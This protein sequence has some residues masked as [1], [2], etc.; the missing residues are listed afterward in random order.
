MR[1]VGLVLAI[2]PLWLGA[3]PPVEVQPQADPQ[4]A[5]PEDKCSIEGQVVNAQTGDPLKKA[6]VRLYSNDGRQ[7]NNYSAVTDGGGHF[8]IQAID[9]GNYT[10]FAERNGFTEAQYGAR[11]AGH[12]ST[13]LPLS[14]GQRIRDLNF[15]LVPF[16]VITGRVLDEDGEPV[17]H[18]NV[19][20]TRYG[21]RR[22]QLSQAGAGQTDDLGEYRIFGL[23]AGKYYLS[24][25]YNQRNL[26]ATQ[27]RTPEHGPDEGYARTFYPGTSDPTGAVAINVVPGAQLR[28]VDITLLKTRTW[29]IRGKVINGLGESLPRPV[30]IML[31]PREKA[32]MG[33][34]PSATTQI[35]DADGTFALRGVTSGAYILLAQC[36]DEGKAYVARQPVDVGNDNVENISLLLGSGMDLKGVVRVDGPGGTALGN[37]QVSLAPQEMLRMGMQGAKVAD[38]GSF[39][40]SNV[41]PATYTIDV[42][43]ISETFYLKSVRLGDADGLEAGL[44][45]THGGAGTLEIVLSPNGGQV[46]GSVV[47]SKQ[48]AVSNAALVLAPEGRRRE[49][50]SFFKMANADAQG[51]FTIKGIAPGE[52]KLFAWSQ[53][54]DPDYQDPEFLKPY[55]NQGEAVA[56]RENSRESVQLKLI[57]PDTKA[58]KTGN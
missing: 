41:P 1:L 29:R 50:R 55:E 39:S 57:E 40:L 10:L 12:G 9:P 51:H 32:R 8:I 2:W 24:A 43:G 25:T 45:L 54:D 19:A 38:D 3:Q 42:Y 16:G 46:D 34:Y 28:G 7:N 20:V 26:M 44:D 31:L 27:D 17:E 13:P 36:W 48:A 11:G 58:N 30:H 18:V 15:R 23:E 53:I 47:D 37:L 4:P 14:P 22:A 6:R 49:L 52:Y 33:Y 35:R 56:I 21:S 5:R